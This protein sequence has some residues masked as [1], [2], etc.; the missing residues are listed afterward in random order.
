MRHYVP[1]MRN[2]A[3]IICIKKRNCTQHIRTCLS[4]TDKQIQQEAIHIRQC[5]IKALNT[6]S[7]KA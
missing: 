1:V 5:M 3:F 7:C 4:F 2:A 6:I